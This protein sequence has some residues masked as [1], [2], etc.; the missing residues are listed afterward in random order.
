[1]ELELLREVG[2]A[3]DEESMAWQK[4]GVSGGEDGRAKEEGEQGTKKKRNRQ[5]RKKQWAAS[6]RDVDLRVISK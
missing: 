3:T 1:M 5:H 4:E 6:M 2:V